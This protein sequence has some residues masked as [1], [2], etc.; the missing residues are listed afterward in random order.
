MKH[1]E[2][3]YQQIDEILW[4]DWDPIGVNDCEE[5]RDEYRSYVPGLV[6][7]KQQGADLHKIS[8]HLYRIVTVAMGISGDKTLM[9]EHCREIAKKIIDL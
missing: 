7:L 4:C 1:K 6:A 8:K 9:M 3:I 2:L 5:I